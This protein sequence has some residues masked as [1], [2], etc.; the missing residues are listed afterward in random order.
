[1]VFSKVPRT[2]CMHKDEWTWL[3]L[4]GQ[5]PRILAVRIEDLSSDVLEMTNFNLFLMPHFSSGSL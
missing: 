2:A 5:I 4:P 3:S 1:M